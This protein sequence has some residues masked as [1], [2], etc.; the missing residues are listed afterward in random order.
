MKSK[1]RDC[2]GHVF[3]RREFGALAIGLAAGSFALP[4]SAAAAPLHESQVRDSI[5]RTTKLGRVSQVTPLGMQAQTLLTVLFPEGLTSLAAGVREDAA[6]YARAGLDRLLS[7]PETG[8]ALSSCAKDLSVESLSV[9]MPDL[10]LDAGVPKDGLGQALDRVQRE[11]GSPCMFLSLEFGELA[12]T[13][14]KLGPVVG[15]GD[16]AEALALYSD[17]SLRSTCGVVPAAD[18]APKVFYAP[19]EM[20]MKA[21][22]SLLSQQVP[23]IEHVGAFAIT[24]PYNASRREVDMELLQQEDPDLVIFD[25]V[26]VLES[27]WNR[28]GEAWR[29]W[30][31]LPAIRW[32]QFAVSPA[33]MHSWL[34][35]PVFLQTIGVQW[36]ANLFEPGSFDLASTARE[37]YELFYGLEIDRAEASAL[38]GSYDALGAWR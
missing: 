27:L 6:D 34:G 17:E 32:G 20:G 22:K 33:L 1:A 30:K 5:G 10:V 12:P 15:R 24:S 35:S 29:L 23:A 8:A 14:R 7:L 19:H 38:L 4:E 28:E 2:S 31:Q 25:D 16:R 3:N 36:L 18:T 37:Y 9:S 26:D 13:L 21:G 11:T